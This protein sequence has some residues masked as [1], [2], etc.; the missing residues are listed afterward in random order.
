M[1]PL[2]GD[3]KDHDPA[4]FKDGMTGKCLCGSIV[5]TLKDPSLFDGR[6]GHLCHCANCRN[7]SGSYVAAN[8]VIPTEKVTIEDKNGTLK[9]YDDTA[10][11]SGNTVGRY[12]CSN[13]GTWVSQAWM[14]TLK[15]LLKITTV[16]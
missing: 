1:P 2:T 10:S 12:F 4:E 5:V 15:E 7:H 3:P 13:C 8:L 11:A 14:I 9:R 16:Q 6:H